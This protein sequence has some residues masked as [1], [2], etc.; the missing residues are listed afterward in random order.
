MAADN[1][2]IDIVNDHIQSEM[3]EN[4]QTSDDNDSIVKIAAF[5]GYHALN[6]EMSEYREEK[7]CNQIEKGVQTDWTSFAFCKDGM[8]RQM[9]RYVENRYE[10]SFNGSRRTYI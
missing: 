1:T 10:E 4:I 9:S 8:T 7:A 2:A 6:G 3:N 5:S